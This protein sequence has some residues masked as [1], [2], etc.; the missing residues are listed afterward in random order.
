[1]D[2]PLTVRDLLSSYEDLTIDREIGDGLF[3]ISLHGKQFLFI[4]PSE[5]DPLSTADVCLYNDPGFDFPHVLLRDKSIDNDSGLPKGVY[6]AVCLYEHE[7][8]VNSIVSFEDKVLD[9]IDR[10]LELLSMSETEKERE[11]QKEFIYYWNNHAVGDDKYA[12]YLKSEQDF[13]KMDTYYG[14]KVVR[15]IEHETLLSDID[16]RKNDKRKWVQHLENDVFY[17]PISDCRGIL[18]PHRGHEWTIQDIRNIVYA[19]QIEHLSASTFQQ[20]KSVV[21][22][23]QNVILV[24][25]MQTEFSHV[26]FAVRVKCS[27]SHG[28]VLL[29]KLLNDAL[30]VEPLFSSRKDYLYLNE[31]IGNDIGLRNKKILL[32]G[33][34]SLGSYIAL[35][36]VKNGASSIKVYDGDKL[37]DENVLR[38]AYGGITVGRNKAS[39]ISLLLNHIHPEVNVEAKSENISNES[40]IDETKSVD[41]IIFSIGNSDQQLEFN[42][43]LKDVNC[44][45]PVIFAWLEAGGINSHILV[46][47]Y[48]KDGCFE[49]LY[50]DEH[51]SPVNNRARQNPDSLQDKF[52]IRNG[53][54][55]TRAAYGTTT[56]L[57][58]TAA[59][60]DTIQG[61]MLDKTLGSV[62]IDVTPSTVRVSDTK[63]PEEA[64]ACCG[65]RKKQ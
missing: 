9:T 52:T 25:G 55:G 50:T 21:P 36:L 7:S 61:L 16:S 4:P 17:I 39:A 32:I 26:S 30:S 40:L 6:R 38:W 1:M 64:C 19:P 29:E 34:G 51:G 27:N 24:F 18:P 47:D 63:F 12:I 46:V 22:M 65:N 42:R 45:V 56:L 44:S 49:C 53:C 43:T 35:E 15:L 3:L 20:L 31:Q 59:L 23:T 14:E 8:I 57:R 13:A 11:F 62:L 33:A 37:E 60:L 28:H 10:L 5:N 58:T 48:Q 54:G 41:L 2:K